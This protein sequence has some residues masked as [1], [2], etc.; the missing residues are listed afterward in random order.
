MSDD[1]ERSDSAPARLIYR[2]REHV[3]QVRNQFWREGINGQPSA[4]TKRELATACIQYWD[5][6]YEFRDESVLEEGDFPDVEPVR[7]RV[8][9]MTE[10]LEQ[11]GRR[12]GS[13]TVRQVP[14]VME[15]DGWYLVSLTK[16]LDDLANRLGFG[17][18]TREATPHDDISHD[19]LAA[20]LEAR[21][22]DEA[23]EKVPGGD[24]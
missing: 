18:S 12:G 16:D 5:V 9:Q 3:Q 21:D 11:S 6:L 24:G 2:M 19:D 8:G 1:D 13:Q 7:S 4:A 22:Q 20:L 23:L 10:R 17:A 14:A 15:L